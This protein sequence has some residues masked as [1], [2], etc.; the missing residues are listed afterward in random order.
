MD[1]YITIKEAAEKWSLSTRRVQMMCAKGRING[2]IKFG[3]V[4]AVPRDAEKPA[5]ARITSGE[6][7]NWRSKRS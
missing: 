1:G 7:I 2:A 4:W 6:Y 5:D 3:K